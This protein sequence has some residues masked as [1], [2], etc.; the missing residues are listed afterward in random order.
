MYKFIYDI[1]TGEVYSAEEVRTDIIESEDEGLYTDFI[2][3]NC[4]LRVSEGKIVKDVTP[5]AI[6]E[7][8]VPPGET[9]GIP[10]AEYN[11]E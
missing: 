1:H 2:N 5:V 7:N 9:V 6:E 4:R 3:G 8:I 10:L 11:K